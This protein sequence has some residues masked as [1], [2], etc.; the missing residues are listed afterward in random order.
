[1]VV[2]IDGTTARPD[3]SVYHLT[4]SLAPGRRAVESNEVITTFGWTPLAPEP[5][6]LTPAEIGRSSAT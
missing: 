3:G 2:E 6:R 1:M 5:L 4:W